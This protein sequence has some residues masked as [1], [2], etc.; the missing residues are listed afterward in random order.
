MPLLDAGLLTRLKRTRLV[1]RTAFPDSG[2]GERQSRNKGAGLEFEDYREYQPGD[3]VRHLDPHVYSRLG[4]HVVRQ[5]A[6]SQQLQV[7]VLVDC[8]NSMDAGNPSKH[9]VALQ[10]AAMV[11][12]MSA[13]GGDRVSVGKI[14]DGKLQQFPTFSNVRQ[15]PELFGWLEAGSAHGETALLKLAHTSAAAL[16][17]GGMLVVISDWLAADFREAIGIWR[18][19]GQEVI[20]LHVLTPEEIEPGE[21]G[22]GP[23]VMSD[24]ETGA[25]LEI[26]LNE[27]SLASYRKIL[28]DWLATLRQEL[29]S[30]GGQHFLIRTNSSLEHDVLPDWQRKGLVR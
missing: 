18:S 17:K 4:T 10:L 21:T 23:V 1:T 29:Q 28:N 12:Y 14:T 13:A 3:D 27:A 22:Q 16:Q 30:G 26:S 5:F 19:R 7:T 8:S 20:G 2:I 25:Q 11:A 24:A 6:L 9:R 15:T